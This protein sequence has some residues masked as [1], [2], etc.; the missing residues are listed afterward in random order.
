MTTPQTYH[1]TNY[2]CTTCGRSF[3]IGTWTG[4]TDPPET[5]PVLTCPHCKQTALRTSITEKHTITEYLRLK[6]A[7][8]S[9][10]ET[11]TR[12]HQRTPARP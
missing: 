6:N 1:I 7:I 3:S 2:T 5:A 12:E 9:L 11:R 8:T 4:T 10:I